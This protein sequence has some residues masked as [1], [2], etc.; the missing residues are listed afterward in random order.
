[1]IAD[2]LILIVQFVK[3]ERKMGAGRTIRFTLHATSGENENNL[4][5]QRSHDPCA[6]IFEPNIS[7]DGD[8]FL[9]APVQL[10]EKEENKM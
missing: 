1:M 10:P 7:W 8:G 2:I 3:K 5:A 9:L 6:C 4:A